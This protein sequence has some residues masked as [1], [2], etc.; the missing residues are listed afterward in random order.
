MQRELPRTVQSMTSE[1]QGVSSDDFEIILYENPS[2]SVLSEECISQFPRNLKYVLSDQNLPLTKAMNRAENLAS[3]SHLLLCVDGAR[4]LSSGVLRYCMMALKIDLRA[5]VA[6]HG[7][8]MG[9]RPQQQ[10][11]EEG[12]HSKKIEDDFLA[13]IN[14]PKHPQFLLNLASWEGSS[15]RGWFF[16]MAESNCLMMERNHFHR[17]GGFDERLKLPGGGI[18]NLDLYSRA[19]EDQSRK[20]F[21]VL[22]EGTFH[23][24]HDG[25]T[26]SNSNNKYNQYLKDYETSIGKAYR[27][28]KRRNYE[29]LGHLPPTALSLAKTSLVRRIEFERAVRPLHIIKK[30]REIERRTNIDLPTIKGKLILIVGMHRSGTSFV[31]RQFANNGFSIPGTPLGGDSQSNPFGHF[32][33]HEIVILHNLILFDQGMSW[34]AFGEIEWS[35][36]ASDYL[37]WR[38]Q[39]LHKLLIDGMSGYTEVEIPDNGWLIKDPRLCRLLPLWHKLFEHFDIEHCTLFV[40]RHPQSVAESLYQRNNLSLEYGRL[41]WARYV[42]DMLQ[43]VSI[44]E[45][46][47]IIDNCEPN[48]FLKHISKFSLRPSPN[49]EPIKTTKPKNFINDRI[50]AIYDTFVET[51][52]ISQM[53]SD[54]QSELSFFSKYPTVTSQMDALSSEIS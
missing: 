15:N 13:E 16:H 41:L 21:F 24:H 9:L 28:P 6:F 14:F 20:L 35:E 52:D 43:H 38:M 25:D 29:Y 50:S 54:L 22:G 17:I 1:Y 3:G 47:L 51:R 8:H 36:I 46:I 19:V 39:T 23:Q 7:L 12:S 18:A 53:K 45:D 31:A 11:L 44:P 5:V 37:E 27:F 42:Y 4:I 32:E 26:A 49:V 10:A 34:R 30:I 2:K 33:P 48:E 40:L